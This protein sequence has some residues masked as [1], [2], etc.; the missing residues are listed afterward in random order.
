VNDDYHPELAEY[1]PH[2][3]RPLRS[4]RTMLMMRALVIVTLAALV[5]PGVLTSVSFAE[6]TALRVCSIWV[7][8]SVAEQNRAE[9]RFEWFSHDGIA[10]WECYAITASGEQHVRSLGVIPEAPELPDGTMLPAVD[11]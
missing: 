3:D 9:V 11:L 2:G 6:A 4:R 5:V 7:Q 8:Y 10:G 1:E